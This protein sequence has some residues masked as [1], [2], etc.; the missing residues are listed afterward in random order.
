MV[1]A[2]S[3]LSFCACSIGYYC[4]DIAV[5]YG[6]LWCFSA[7]NEDAGCIL[8]HHGR[9]PDGCQLSCQTHFVGFEAQSM[10]MQRMNYEMKT[11][12]KLLSNQ[13]HKPRLLPRQWMD[14]S[15]H[16]DSGWLLRDTRGHLKLLIDTSKCGQELDRMSWAVLISRN[17]CI[18]F[19]VRLARL[20]SLW[21]KHQLET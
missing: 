12:Q 3:P 18:S 19:V 8:G 13:S 10:Q 15:G 1:S 6:G 11:C 16:H 5:W 17:D 9:I 7:I 4:Y 20:N 2:L 21:T 14:T